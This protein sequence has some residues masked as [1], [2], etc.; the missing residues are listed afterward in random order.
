MWIRDRGE[1]DRLA[2]Y[3]AALAGGCAAG[4]L[5][6]ASNANRAPVCDALSPVW[7][8]AMVAAG[9]VAVA[10]A[11]LS[12]RTPALRLAAGAVGGVLIAGAFA[13][14]WPHCLGRLEGVSPELQ[15]LWLDNVREARPIYVHSWATIF[16]VLPLPIAGLIGYGV[17]LWRNRRDLDALIPWAVLAAL[18]LLAALLLLW[19]TRAGPAA[20]LLSIAGVTGLGWWLLGLLARWPAGPLRAVAIA[21]AFLLVSGLGAQNLAKLIPDNRSQRLQAVN[22]ANAR[23]PTLP[24]LRPIALL[25]RGYVLTFVDLGPRLITVTHHDA[26]AGPYHRNQQAIVDVMKSFRGTPEYAHQVVRRRGVDYVLIC[27]GMSESTLYAS[28]APNGF[29]RQ[30]ARGQVPAWLQPVSLPKGSPYRMWRVRR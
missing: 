9:A 13:L 21:A 27:P 7:L 17:M 14:L 30:L 4:Y 1:A 5:L 25:P 22:R 18:A 29:Y 19:Q 16:G 26:V 15:R 23:C 8:S 20:Q 3:G 11:F 28:A 2:A 6:F 12:P 10:L 24:A